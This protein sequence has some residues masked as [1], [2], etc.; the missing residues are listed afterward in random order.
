MKS[1]NILCVKSQKGRRER[2]RESGAQARLVRAEESKRS[3]RGVLFYTA[4]NE[5]EF[6][7]SESK[8]DHST[9]MT[10]SKLIY[11]DS[12]SSGR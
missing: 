5:R 1:K 9:L 8:E 6:N 12:N 7:K 10:K 3:V 11:P 2:E 4:V